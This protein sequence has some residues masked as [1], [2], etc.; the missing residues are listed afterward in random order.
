[1]EG[2]FGHFKAYYVPHEKVTSEL[3][4]TTI[5]IGRRLETV[6][7]FLVLW[8]AQRVIWRAK[9]EAVPGNASLRGEID[10]LLPPAFE[11]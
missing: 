11:L 6:E 7:P 10:A 3:V 9:F 5:D 1:M 2:R 4:L 8:D